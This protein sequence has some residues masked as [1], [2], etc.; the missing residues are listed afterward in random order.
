MAIRRPSVPC[1]LISEMNA[2]HGS[3]RISINPVRNARRRV[4]ALARGGMGILP[5]CISRRWR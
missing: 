5:L 1:K 3:R 2:G 4:R